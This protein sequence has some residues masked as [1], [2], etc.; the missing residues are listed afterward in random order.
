MPTPEIIVSIQTECDTGS[1]LIKFNTSI[2]AVKP[3]ERVFHVKLIVETLSI[4][5][6]K[7]PPIMYYDDSYYLAKLNVFEQHA[8]HLLFYCHDYLPRSFFMFHAP[9]SFL[10]LTFLLESLSL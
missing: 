10:E 6:I 1:G 8:I 5:R 3:N 7:I 2:N 4:T 9:P